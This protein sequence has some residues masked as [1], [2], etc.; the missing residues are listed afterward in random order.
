MNDN[1]KD[2][3]NGGETQQTIADDLAALTKAASPAPEQ[4]VG[5]KYVN[6]PPKD[7]DL[8]K[9]G[10]FLDAVF[11]AGLD[12]DENILTWIVPPTR[13]P[14]F[15]ISEEK[16]K[17]RL[18]ATRNSCALYYATATCKRDTDGKLYHRKKLF[19][20]LRVVVLDDIGTKVPLDKIPAD[21]PPSYIIESRWTL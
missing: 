5:L 6:I 1:T 7:Y 12:D 19:S 15:P 16:M 17:E 21:F 3:D 2:T 10:S 13:S 11:H 18:S 9:I 8:A 14:S 20:S 4:S